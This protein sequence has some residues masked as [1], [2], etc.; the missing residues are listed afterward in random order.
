MPRFVIDLGNIDM[1]QDDVERLNAE[2]QKVALT[3]VA[4]LRLDKPLAIKFPRPFPWGI[5]IGPDF[6]NVLQSE[7]LIEKAF[8]GLQ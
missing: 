2:L 8:E 5:I 6:D 1:A 3:H 4:E 7:A